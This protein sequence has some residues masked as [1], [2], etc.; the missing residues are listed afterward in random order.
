MAS[1]LRAFSRSS[2][3][4]ATLFVVL[5]APW[6]SGT[7]AEPL[8]GI[9]NPRVKDGTWVTDLPRALRA[10]T[11]A[12]LNQTFGDLERT[13]GIE[14]ALVVVRSL[15]GLSIEEAAAK[16][17]KLWGIGKKDRDNGL[18]FLW[19]TGDR[20]V[21]VE[22]GYGLEGILPDGKVG[23]IL[24][25]YVIPRFKAGE[26]D[27]GIIAG[28]DAVVAAARSEDVALPAMATESYERPDWMPWWLAPLGGVPVVIGAIT[29]FRRWRRHRRRDCPQC[30]TRMRCLS[31]SEDDEQLGAG[32][33]AEERIGSV[34]YDVWKCPSCS[35]SVHVALCEMAQQ[36][37]QVPAVFQ[38]HE[39]VDGTRHHRRDH[40]LQRQRAGPREMCI[41]QFH[42]RVHQNPAAHRRVELLVIIRKLWRQ[43][44]RRRQ[45][46]RRRSEPRVLAV[47]FRSSRDRSRRA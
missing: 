23:A 6:V 30:R 34:D 41:L 39:V 10:D 16:L 35:L 11:V 43:Q 33:V 25:A 9:P 32:Q 26:F 27:A 4:G 3:I 21:R 2:F 13:H 7:S 19:S 22:V 24:D 29:V 45:F 5:A 8:A 40:D 28:V 14:M 46:R 1:R 12:R 20:K 47:T 18:L 17:F 38:S 37:R 36:V 42:E 31:D 44:L 15:D